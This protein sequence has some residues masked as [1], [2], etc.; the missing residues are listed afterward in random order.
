MIKIIILLFLLVLLLATTCTTDVAGTISETDS[1]CAVAG[2]VS[3]KD[4]KNVQS[5]F[6]ILHDIGN[7][8]STIIAQQRPLHFSDT[9][10]TDHYGHFQFDS[11]DTG[12]FLIEVIHQDSL[13]TITPIVIKQTD[14]LIEAAG[15]LKPAGAII[16]KIDSSIAASKTKIAIFIRE[17]GRISRVDSSGTFS[18]SKLAQWEYHLSIISDTL[19]DKLPL[20]TALI[21]VVSGTTSRVTGIGSPEGVIVVKDSILFKDISINTDSGIGGSIAFLGDDSIL[22]IRLLTG[23]KNHYQQVDIKLSKFIT[24]INGSLNSNYFPLNETNSEISTIDN[25]SL[26]NKFSIEEQGSYLF[27]NINTDTTHLRGNLVIECIPDNQSYTPIRI[28]G[29]FTADIGPD[30]ENSWDCDFGDT[31]ST[32]WFLYY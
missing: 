13:S 9:T 27:L 17:L 15:I 25:G 29:P 8:H 22:K 4:G 31:I 14:T 30:A 10:V 19:I 12:N 6:V 21:P 1:G 24:N 16:G 11:V 5:A 20:A 7:I 28:R 26:L 3:D 32:C 18:F 23:Q 2:T